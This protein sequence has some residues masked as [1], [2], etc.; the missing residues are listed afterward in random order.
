MFN[1]KKKEPCICFHCIYMVLLKKSVQR[2][3][4][5]YQVFCVWVAVLCLLGE[6]PFCICV[7]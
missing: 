7:C 4:E 6:T 1:E 5:D 2:F 3:I